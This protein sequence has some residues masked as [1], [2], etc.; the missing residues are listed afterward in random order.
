[1]N[2]RRFYQRSAGLP[3]DARVDTPQQAAAII[4]AQQSLG[5]QTGLVIGV[6]A[7]EAAAVSGQQAEAWIGQALADAE[8]RNITGKAS[9]PFLLARVAELSQGRSL[10]ANLA[11]VENN[12]RVA[13]QIAVALASEPA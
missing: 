12:A 6:P 3:V 10:Q 4:R 13:A 1:M 5:L 8:A 2:F 9:T 7:P 11:L